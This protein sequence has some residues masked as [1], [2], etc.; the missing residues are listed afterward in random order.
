[1]T[2]G[3]GTGFLAGS[4]TFPFFSVD[5]AWLTPLGRLPGVELWLGTVD[6]AVAAVTP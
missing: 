6:L 2:G 5:A 4:L 3:E 1:M